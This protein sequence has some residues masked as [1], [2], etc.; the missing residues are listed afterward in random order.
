MNFEEDEIKIDSDYA[1]QVTGDKPDIITERHTTHG[2]FNQNAQISQ[3][4]KSVICT[5]ENWQ[6]LNYRQKEAL[7]MIA[8]KIS[9]ILSGHAD[10]ADHWDDIIGYARLAKGDEPQTKIQQTNVPNHTPPDMFEDF[11]METPTYATIWIAWGHNKTVAAKTQEDVIREFKLFIGADPVG[12]MCIP[13]FPQVDAQGNK[14]I[15]S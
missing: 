12:A 14:I 11:G 1:P 7:D 4:L 3:D 5:G 8:L 2:D 9:R 6:N 15:R 10:H 13:Y